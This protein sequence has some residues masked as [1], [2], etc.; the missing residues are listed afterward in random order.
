[1]DVGRRRGLGGVADA[2]RRRLRNSVARGLRGS[3]AAVVEGVVLGE[4][5]GLSAELRQRFRAAGLYHLLAV[6]GQNVALV[7]G[8]ALVFAWLVGVPR[9]LAEV[10]AL[11]A[12]FAYLQTV[13]AVRNRVPQ[14]VAADAAATAT[15]AKK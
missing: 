14:P 5:T 6:S 13:P 10:G 1:M 2:V 15:A 4:D 7:A 3:R 9:L 8:S 11:A 12:I